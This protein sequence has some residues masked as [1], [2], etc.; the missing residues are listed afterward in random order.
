[1]M[2]LV[3]QKFLVQQKLLVH[4][5]PLFEAVQLVCL[6]HR[7]TLH[8]VITCTSF[9]LIKSMWNVVLLSI[10]INIAPKYLLVY[11]ESNVGEPYYPSGHVIL[12]VCC[13]GRLSSYFQFR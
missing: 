10:F 7:L 4:H 3:H 9:S 12:L 13:E 1:M 5:L 2:F 11:R 6:V 8:P